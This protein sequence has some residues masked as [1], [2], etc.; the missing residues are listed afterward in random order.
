MPNA[1][2]SNLW[3]LFLTVGPSCLEIGYH[4]LDFLVSWISEVWKIQQVEKQFCSFGLFLLLNAVQFLY[5]W[6]LLSDLVWILYIDDFW[7]FISA[8]QKLIVMLVTLLLSF[9]LFVD[10]F[11][12]KIRLLLSLWLYFWHLSQYVVDLYKIIRLSFSF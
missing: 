6:L 7:L 3:V 9:W 4:G 5:L 12:L 2:Q 11:V 8:G 1:L 10:L